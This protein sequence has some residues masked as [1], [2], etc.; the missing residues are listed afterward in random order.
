MKI[1]N[2]KNLYHKTT[3]NFKKIK[4]LLES[5]GFK[6]VKRYDWKDTEHSHIDDHSQAYFPHMDKENGKLISLN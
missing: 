2:K 6:N 4:N 1:N 3:Y 5:S